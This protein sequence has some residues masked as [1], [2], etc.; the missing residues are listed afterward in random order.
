[1][2]SLATPIADVFV[3]RPH[4]GWATTSAQNSST[5]SNI[6]VGNRLLV[7]RTSRGLSQQELSER[8]GIDRN[9]L[10]AYEAGAARINANLLLQIAKLLDVRPDYFLQG[11]TEEELESCLEWRMD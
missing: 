5:P 2:T 11:Y 4:R 1:M 9:D 10:G 6:C 3:K 7:R 8:L